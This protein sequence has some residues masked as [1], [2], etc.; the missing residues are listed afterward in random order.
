MYKTYVIFHI[1]LTMPHFYCPVCKSCRLPS[2]QLMLQHISR[3][4]S[5]APSFNVTCGL[6]GC[7]R[8]YTNYGSYQKHVKGVH[9]RYFIAATE[10]PADDIIINDSSMEDEDVDTQSMD[11]FESF[12]NPSPT[13]EIEKQ[14]L[15]AIW[16]LKIRE[17]NMLTQSCMEK[18][19]SDVTDMCTN[20][21]DELKVD[22][23]QKL[24]LYQHHHLLSRK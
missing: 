14:R 3:V 19:L 13:S 23:V 6:D 10:L 20:I 4:H 1:Q 24:D 2:V 18:L 9:S 15:R 17:T 8:T 12:V 5:T 16:I 22:I 7:L 11:E 21:I